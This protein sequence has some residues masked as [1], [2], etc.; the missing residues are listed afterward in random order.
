MGM[1]LSGPTTSDPPAPAAPK[2]ADESP[3]STDL[4]VYVAVVALVFAVIIAAAQTSH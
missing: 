2:A 4:K 1:E 3:K